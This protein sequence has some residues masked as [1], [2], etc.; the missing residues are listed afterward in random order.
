M[1]FGLSS[2]AISLIGAGAGLLGSKSGATSGSQTQ[3]KSI[4]PFIK[5]KMDSLLGDTEALYK[6]QQQNGGLNPLMQAGLLQQAGVLTDPN[7]NTGYNQMRNLGSSLMSGGM[8]GNPFTNGSWADGSFIKGT[9]NTG[10]QKTAT[11]GGIKPVTGNT[12]YM[13]QVDISK[14]MMSMDTPM[15][16]TPAVDPEYEAYKKWLEDQKMSGFANPLNDAGGL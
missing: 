7:Y 14:L 5:A 2:G 10:Q 3:T 1:A 8:A 13:P 6:Q 15:T 9:P 4:D 16:T 11:D 12:N